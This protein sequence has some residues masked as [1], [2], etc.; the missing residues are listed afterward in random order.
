MNLQAVEDF[1]ILLK[2]ELTAVD[3]YSKAIDSVSNKSALPVLEECRSSHINR[4]ARL[5]EAIKYYGGKPVE[6]AGSWEK[7]TRILTE[8]ATEFGEN[9]ILAAIEEGENLELNDY[10]WRLRNMHGEH[11]NLLKY[12][13]YPAQ[14]QTHR[15]ISKLVNKL[16]GYLAAYPT[17]RGHL[18][19]YHYQ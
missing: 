17:T 5:R 9:A 7:F 11:R 10:E 1:N 2:S 6:N 14:Q 8:F 16:S 13:L 4:S 15:Q 12:D 3:A 18:N 19:L